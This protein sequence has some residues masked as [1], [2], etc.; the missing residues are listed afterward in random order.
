VGSLNRIVRFDESA[1]IERI[2]TLESGDE[3]SDPSSPP[4]RAEAKERFRGGV[5][6]PE[7]SRAEVAVLLYW[8]AGR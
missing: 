3:S 4:E 6:A 8:K 2:D 5:R 7:R 1:T